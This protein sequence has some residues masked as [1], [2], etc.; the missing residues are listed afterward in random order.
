VNATASMLRV[1]IV[2]CNHALSSSHWVASVQVVVMV[3]KM[4][5]L[6]PRIA[7]SPPHHARVTPPGCR[8]VLNACPC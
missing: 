1:R 7:V 3:V 2:P 5:E 4:H 8:R 6:W